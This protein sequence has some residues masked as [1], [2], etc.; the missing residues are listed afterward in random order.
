MLSQPEMLS[1]F[2]PNTRYAFGQNLGSH[3]RVTKVTVEQLQKAA[4]PKITSLDAAEQVLSL[5]IYRWNEACDRAGGCKQYRMSESFDA[6]PFLDT[7]A[8]AE[9]VRVVNNGG[10][11]RDVDGFV[12]HEGVFDIVLKVFKALI[13]GNARGRAA[14][15]ARAKKILNKE[16]RDKPH[17]ALLA[18][19]QFGKTG[20]L[21]SSIIFY[22]LW[23]KTQGIKEIC[24]LINPP[25]RA[26]AAQ[27]NKDFNYAKQLLSA[28]TFAAYPKITLFEG[29]ELSFSLINENAA[30]TMSKSK[31][32]KN[33]EA[34]DWIASFAQE[35]DLMVTL[36]IDEADEAVN[37]K[38][39]FDHALQ[40]MTDYGVTAR[41]LMCSATAWV[42]RFLERFE[43]IEVDISDR[44]YSGT[45][46][47]KRT[48]VI[49][50]TALSK[51]INVPRLATFDLGEATLNFKVHN[52]DMKGIYEG[53][54]ET[55]AEARRQLDLDHK[56]V[57]DILTAFVCGIKG[58]SKSKLNGKPFNGGSAGMIRY[59][60][61]EQLQA[62]LN[63]IETRLFED[64]GVVILR[65]FTGYSKSQS[66]KSRDA[67]GRTCD[68]TISGYQ[69]IPEM[70]TAAKRVG[71]TKY[72]VAVVD[73]AR[74]ADRFNT[75]CTVFLDF[76]ATFGTMTSMEQGTMGRASG[77]NKITKSQST[78]VMLSDYN[79]SKV[80]EFRRLFDRYK[81]KRA[82]ITAANNAINELPAA[83]KKKS[84]SLDRSTAKGDLKL[85][86][87]RIDETIGE[88]IKWSSKPASF[89]DRAA[90]AK[91]K[92][93]TAAEREAAWLPKPSFEKDYKSA[94]LRKGQSASG[95]T[96]LYWNISG[97][98]GNDLM[99]MIERTAQERFGNNDVKLMKPG[100]TRGGDGRYL[101]VLDSSGL[102]AFAGRETSNERKFIHISIGNVD[103][104]DIQGPGRR[105]LTGDRNSRKPSQKSNNKDGKTIQIDFLFSKEKGT[106]E[107]RLQ[108]ITFPLAGEFEDHQGVAA[109]ETKRVYPNSKSSV[110]KHI[111]TDREH[112]IIKALE[113]AR[114]ARN[115]TRK[116]RAVK[117]IK[118]TPA[119]IKR[120][121]LDA[122]KAALT[123]F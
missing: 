15:V 36:I 26:P 99:K 98:L 30:N 79:A 14:N 5:S 71:V 35:N 25:R 58:D 45:V 67:S 32:R 111:A 121:K 77:W 113:D 42:Y 12:A 87:D 3:E 105:G 1:S 91:R 100:Y 50:M 27:T 21:A 104:D 28:I 63:A 48:P 90:T 10:S 119:E 86:F 59:G 110:K 62:L 74:R 76:T 68:I 38:S 95:Q 17:I 2:T 22:N 57:Y 46:T 40:I 24:V 33:T 56:M 70:V 109:T 54:E 16:L 94:F 69:T 19:T 37:L 120:A 114:K 89:V 53:D 88:A 31:T 107:T 11:I 97:I 49:S 51:L 23:C 82:V 106:G 108:R 44:R 117:P 52:D 84:F 93:M 4:K 29:N 34:L 85:V 61:T 75:E 65:Q 13:R 112:A 39:F 8:I 122:A 116:P 78:I 73:A 41:L 96:W 80:A 60:D 7:P 6:R 83:R 9:L 55:L 18:E 72:I 64:H 103:R 115:S 43:C 81:E 20:I 102:H 123:N 66:I 47:K 92:A 118:Q 101:G